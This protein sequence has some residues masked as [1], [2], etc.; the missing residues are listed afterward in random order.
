MVPSLPSPSASCIWPCPNSTRS[1]IKI[2]YS[3]RPACPSETSL[4]HSLSTSPSGKC[5]WIMTQHFLSHLP[6]PSPPVKTEKGL[7]SIGRKRTH[8]SDIKDYTEKSLDE[9]GYDSVVRMLVCLPPEGSS[10]LHC[11]K[12][13]IQ[14]HGSTGR[15]ATTAIAMVVVVVAINGSTGNSSCPVSKFVD[16]QQKCGVTLRIT[17]LAFISCYRQVMMTSI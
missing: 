10:T 1:K 13:I 9:F 15:S 8:K 6:S 4:P 17:L 16:L 2:T 14:Q 11:N 5:F 12:D 7:L 3:Q